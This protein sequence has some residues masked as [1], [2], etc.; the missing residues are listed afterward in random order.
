MEL[1]GGT[2]WW[3]HNATSLKTLGGRRGGG[4]GWRDRGSEIRSSAKLLKRTFNGFNMR[5]PFPLSLAERQTQIGW[6]HST[7]SHNWSWIQSR[8][9]RWPCSPLSPPPPPPI[10]LPLR[11]WS[12]RRFIFHADSHVTLPYLLSLSLPKNL[13]WELELIIVFQFVCFSWRRP[14][15]PLC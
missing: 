4:V 1:A 15:P 3:V 8:R 9:Y 5:N 12:H 7:P 10:H 14:L 2:R 6:C 11:Q 13:F